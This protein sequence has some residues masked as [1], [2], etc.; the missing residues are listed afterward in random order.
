MVGKGITDSLRAFVEIAFEQIAE[1]QH[2]RHG[3]EGDRVRGFDPVQH[4]QL[5]RAVEC[6][7]SLY[8]EPVGP[9]LPPER[10]PPHSE[11]VRRCRPASAGFFQ[12]DLD[13]GSLVGHGPAMSISLGGRRSDST[14]GA[15]LLG[16]MVRLD[17]AASGLDQ[18]ALE[19]GEQLAD[20]SRPVVSLKL[21]HS[22]W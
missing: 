4:R 11:D 17:A 1:D 3:S 9:H 15:D 5:L 14:G 8:D 7:V 20:I 12:S 21:A 16:E 19:G 18:S 10:G 22:Q 13:G 2:G 6:V